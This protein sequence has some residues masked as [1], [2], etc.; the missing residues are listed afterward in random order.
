MKGDAREWGRSGL[1]LFVAALSLMPCGLQ[2]QSRDAAKQSPA[3]KLSA[4]DHTFRIEHGG[5]SREYIVHVPAIPD[6]ARSLPLLFAFHGGGGEAEQYQKSAGLDAVSDREKFVV[7]YPYGTGALPRR[8]LTWNAGECCGPAMNRNVDDV[9]FAIAV[10]DDVMRRTSID[11]GR[12]YATGHS[13]GAMMAYRF[14][15]ERADR[16]VAIAPVAG[17]YNLGAFAPTRP[18]AVLDIH[19]EG[20]PRALY[21][22]GMGPSFPGTT[23]KSS[24]RPVM[25]G[26]NR[27]TRNNKCADSTVTEKRTGQAGTNNTGQTATLITWKRCAA[28][29]DVAHWKLTG[30]GHGWPGD[31][32]EAARE[33]TIGKPTTLVVAAEEVW[34]F[35]SKVKR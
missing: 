34:K 26:I 13:N 5:R 6:N 3:V 18:V 2:A 24:H 10:L 11:K 16:I 28:G 22:G 27:W 15:A 21:N 32:Q 1:V 35:V 4:G 29:G 17:A 7:V 14:G 8:L 31:V 33:R 9:G 25:E 12:V 19:S 30:V 23:V 20:D